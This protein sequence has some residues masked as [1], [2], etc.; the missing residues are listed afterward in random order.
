[1]A[2]GYGQLRNAEGL[3]AAATAGIRHF[4]LRILRLRG[5]Q[6]QTLVEAAGAVALQIECHVSVPRRFQL[7]ADRR[8]G[9]RFE[10]P[11]HLGVRDFHPREIVVV[12][13][14]ADAKPQPAKRRPL[15]PPVS[16]DGP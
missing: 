7:A 10:R 14:A 16:W 12:T 1:M 15:K 4:A 6:Q 11:R 5:P 2:A 9:F 3:L 8:A 13:D